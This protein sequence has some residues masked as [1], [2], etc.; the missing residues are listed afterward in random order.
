MGAVRV[1]CVAS[2]C[3]RIGAVP[4]NCKKCLKVE[5][6]VEKIAGFT[7]NFWILAKGIARDSQ[8][9]VKH[10]MSFLGHKEKA[11]GF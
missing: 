5:D 11:K 2:R 3:P 4:E 7:N 6:L 8:E 10:L 1:S 9:V